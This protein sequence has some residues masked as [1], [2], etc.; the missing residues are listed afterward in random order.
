[1]NTLKQY[2]PNLI[3][4]TTLA[5]GMSS[6]ALAIEGHL[7]LAG[8]LILAGY[9]LDSVDGGIARRLGVSSEF[10]TQLDSLVDI[11]IFGG[12]GSVLVW[13]HLAETPLIRW[14]YWIFGV[15][16]VLASAYRLARFNLYTDE[17]KQTESLGLT[18]S[19]SG[20]FLALAVLA[21]RAF[22]HLLFPDW[23][24]PLLLFIVSLLMVSRIHFPELHV[25]LSRRRMSIAILST[26]VV[27]AYW[28]TPQLV[29]FG[30]TTGYI[31]F[32]VLRAG[33]RQIV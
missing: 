15:M 25:I 13:Q 33:F 2:A 27:A 3:T 17:T 26:S 11:I 4:F 32:G 20:A 5:C 8:V 1:M 23:I 9:L 6:I 12:A 31:S 22:N 29:W 7:N 10:G 18:T 14:P 16:F 28:L 19:T 30:L 21:D 24:F